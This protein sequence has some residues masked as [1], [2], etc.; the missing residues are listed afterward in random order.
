MRHR[1]RLLI[2]AGLLAGA[3]ALLIYNLPGSRQL[4]LQSDALFDATLVDADNRPQ[5]LAQWRGR[6]LVVNFWASWCPPCL[7]EMPE[8]SHL[9]ETYAQRGLVVLG[10]STDAAVRMQQHARGAPVSYPLLAGDF[11]AMQLAETLGNDRGVLPYTAV[12][13]P[14]GSLA[15]RYFGRLDMQTLEQALRPLLGDAG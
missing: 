11:A 6:L 10:I 9:Q 7:E 12:L 2:A 4:A 13:R 14:D 15:L 8:L 1:A 5:P 3:L